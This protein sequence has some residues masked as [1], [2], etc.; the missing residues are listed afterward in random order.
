MYAFYLLGSSPGIHRYGVDELWRHTAD[1]RANRDVGRGLVIG[2][3]LV[4]AVAGDATAGQ[5]RGLV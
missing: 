5:S 4:L 1:G 3:V 2:T